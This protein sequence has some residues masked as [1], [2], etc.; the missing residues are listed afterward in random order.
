M[1]IVEK[2]TEKTGLKSYC[3]PQERPATKQELAEHIKKAET[4]GRGMTEEE[5]ER[6]FDEFVKK[7]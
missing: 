2:S 5:F 7:F 3:F 1:A 6:K 4:Y